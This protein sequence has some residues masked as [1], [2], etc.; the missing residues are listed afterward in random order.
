MEV[1]VRFLQW[2]R[3][4]FAWFGGMLAGIAL[5]IWIIVDRISDSMFGGADP[6]LVK[7]F[8]EAKVWTAIKLGG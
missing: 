4:G 3:D 8:T 5:L 7:I 2:F 1:S 6:D